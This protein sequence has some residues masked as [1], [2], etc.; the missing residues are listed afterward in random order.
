MGNKN[1]QKYKNKAGY[2]CSEKFSY[3]KIVYITPGC[4]RFKFLM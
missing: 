1:T 4:E 3:T 2:S